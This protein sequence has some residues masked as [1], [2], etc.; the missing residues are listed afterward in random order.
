M[1]KLIPFYLMF[2]ISFVVVPGIAQRYGNVPKTVASN[3]C[4]D[5]HKKACQ[6]SPDE[7]FAYNGQSRSGLFHK[8]QVSIIKSVFYKGMDY[9]ISVCSEDKSQISFT[10]K[11]AKTDE[12]LYDNS[13]DN[14]TQEIQIANENT[15]HVVIQVTIP[16]ELKKDIVKGQEG[17]CAGVLVEHRRS[18]K[19]GF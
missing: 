13:T 17:L 14:N 15:R 3:P 2:A 1:K 5:F 9:H 6:C 19:T 16:G 12:V 10:I 7:G 4:L 18:D 8:G 11:D